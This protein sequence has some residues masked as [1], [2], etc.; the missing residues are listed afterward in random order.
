MTFALLPLLPRSFS[1]MMKS[2]LFFC[3]KRT[4]IIGKSSTKELKKEGQR[5][6]VQATSIKI[7][8]PAEQK[9]DGREPVN[10][11][12]SRANTLELGH[13]TKLG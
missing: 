9:E 6:H 4:A 8:T 13:E 2:N 11:L 1:F 3:Q 10:V 12:L 7:N 5:Q